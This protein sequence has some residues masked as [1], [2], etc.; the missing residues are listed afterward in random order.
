MRII[1]A[2]A[3]GAARLPG[4]VAGLTPLPVVGVPVKGSSSEAVDSLRSIVQMSVSFF[5]L[6]LLYVR[7]RS[8]S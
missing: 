3:G 7:T 5:G 1:I 2:G 4:M 6:V 8:H